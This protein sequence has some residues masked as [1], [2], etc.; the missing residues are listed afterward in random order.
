MIKSRQSKK[1]KVQLTPQGSGR[2]SEPTS[3][4]WEHSHRCAHWAHSAGNTARATFQGDSSDPQVS[5]CSFG[6]QGGAH[7]LQRSRKDNVRHDQ[8]PPDGWLFAVTHKWSF[9]P[10]TN[11]VKWSPYSIA[12]PLIF[13]PCLVHRREILLLLWQDSLDLE[14]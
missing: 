10:W 5:S 3:W 8:T 1:E 4:Q 12:I 14:T 9:P 13:L 11:P 6:Q 7:S 2:Q